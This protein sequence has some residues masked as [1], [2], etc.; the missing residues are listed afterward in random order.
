MYCY[1]FSTD[2]KLKH[3]QR[4]KKTMCYSMIIILGHLVFM[5]LGAAYICT[6]DV[7]PNKRLHQIIQYFSRKMD[8][9]LSNKIQYGDNIF[10]E[11]VSDVVSAYRYM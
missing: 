5:L 9:M 2:P 8:K 6:E 1:I 11:H 4:L 10:I 7:F 3:V